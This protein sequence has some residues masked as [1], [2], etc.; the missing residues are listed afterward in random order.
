MPSALGRG[1]LEDAVDGVRGCPQ[2]PGLGSERGQSSLNSWDLGALCG[3]SAPPPRRAA[4]SKHDPLAVLTTAAVWPAA[5]TSAPALATCDAR[6]ARGGPRGQSGVLLSVCPVAP[7]T[8]LV[9]HPQRQSARLC[10][11]KAKGPGQVEPWAG[12]RRARAQRSP[13]DAPAGGEARALRM[14]AG[15]QGRDGGACVCTCEH[16][17]GGRAVGGADRTPPRRRDPM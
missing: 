12:W 16:E 14:G 6:C 1:S 7:Q 10:T 15:Q 4:L 9:A 2:G 13:R 3:Q 11:L 5:D 8:Q 17:G